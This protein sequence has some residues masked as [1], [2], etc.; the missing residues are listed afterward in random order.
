ML[1]RLQAPQWVERAQPDNWFFWQA[2]NHLRGSRNMGG[3]IPFS[4]I[5]G[6]ADWAGI[7]CPIQRGR[8]VS[9][10]IALDNSERSNGPATQT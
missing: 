8:L 7:T 2:Y 5:R 3:A 10:I 6:Y 9:V 4:E 1:E